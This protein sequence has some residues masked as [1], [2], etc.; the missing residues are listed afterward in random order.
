[1]LCR[2]RLGDK[3]RRRAQSARTLDCAAK[4]TALPQHRQ[5]FPIFVSRERFAA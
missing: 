3:A 2:N 5:H 1:L 4:K